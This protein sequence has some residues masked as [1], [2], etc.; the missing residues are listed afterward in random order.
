MN[1]S[2]VGYGISAMIG[3]IIVIIR[4]V[5]FDMPNTELENMVGISYTADMY[6]ILKAALIPNFEIV[7]KIGMIAN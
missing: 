5:K 1:I 3:A 7:I 4:A 6:T 2:G